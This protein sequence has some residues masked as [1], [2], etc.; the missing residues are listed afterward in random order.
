LT[1]N[2]FFCHNLCC[3]CPNDSCEAIFDI[4]ISIYFQWYE[5]C[6]KARCFDPYN[7]ALKFRESQRTPK[8]PFQECECHPHTLPIVGLQHNSSKS[9]KNKP[10]F[11]F[12]FLH[13]FTWFTLM[14][15]VNKFTTYTTCMSKTIYVHTTSHDKISSTYFLQILHKL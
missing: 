2:P 6:F 15:S 12:N 7:Q 11:F 14:W 13:G 8:S 9:W 5:E 10:S 1:P 4:Y 3:I